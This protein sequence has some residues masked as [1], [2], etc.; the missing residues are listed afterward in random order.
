[1]IDFDYFVVEIHTLLPRLMEDEILYMRNHMDEDD[2]MY[3][4]T[5]VEAF[6]GTPPPRLIYHDLL[7]YAEYNKRLH[8]MEFTAYAKYA[9]TNIRIDY[10]AS[11]A[12]FDYDVVSKIIS[13][14]FGSQKN[15]K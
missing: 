12:G 15:H 1:M 13:H 5:Q 11:L 2:P 9:D 8:V 3:L 6:R 7:V 14:D 4:P 10:A